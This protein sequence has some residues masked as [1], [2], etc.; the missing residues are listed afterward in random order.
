MCPL[1]ICTQL[2]ISK[3]D[4]VKVLLVLAMKPPT[5][6]P[7]VAESWYVSI[8]ITIKFFSCKK[9][10][11]QNYYCLKQQLNQC[12][13]NILYVN[14][15][16]MGR[17]V[18]VCVCVCITYWYINRP[19]FSSKF[20]VDLKSNL[21]SHT[22]QHLFLEDSLTDNTLRRNWRESKIGEKGRGKEKEWVIKTCYISHTRRI[23]TAKLLYSII[24][25]LLLSW[26]DNNNLMKDKD[27]NPTKPLN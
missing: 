10:K 22:H 24:Q 4:L 6:R 13:S 25:I 21:C 26:H 1:Q 8:P 27:I 2:S 17:G 23:N 20:T 5:E 19:K 15:R 16:E 14:S 12:N 3:P 18:C 7:L 9:N 11:K